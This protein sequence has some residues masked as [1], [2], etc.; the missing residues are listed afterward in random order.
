MSLG[1]LITQPKEKIVFNAPFIADQYTGVRLMN[2]D[3]T[4]RIGYRIKAEDSI[5]ASV[6]PDKGLLQPGEHAD[7]RV[8][9][10]KFLWVPE[11]EFKDRLIIEWAPVPPDVNEFQNA[12]FE[13]SFT[14]RRLTLAIAHNV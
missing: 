11:Q 10:R 3:S 1:D 8:D 6:K 2:G 12:W 5:R 13:A 14:T 4:N 7:I 9:Y